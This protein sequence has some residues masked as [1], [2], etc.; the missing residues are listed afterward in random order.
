MPLCVVPWATGGILVGQELQVVRQDDAGYRPLCMRDP[1]GAI[2]QMAH[3]LGD[4]GHADKLAGNVLEKVLQV[5]LLLIRSAE[6]RARLLADQRNHRHMVELGVVKAIQQMN[7]ART[8]RRVAKA[9]LARELG[10]RRRHKG[11]HLL[12]ADLDVFHKILGL[13]QGYI[14][15][16]DAVARITVD[17]LEPPFRQSPPNKFADIPAHF[18]CPLR[19]LARRICQRACDVSV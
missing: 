2:D 11:R 9:H 6:S 7:R 13:L 3:L 5:D 15:A 1:H 8:G 12:V 4:A 16:A 18:C 17:P 14:Q 10:V 19:K